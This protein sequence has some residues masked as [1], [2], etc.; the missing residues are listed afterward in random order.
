MKSIIALFNYVINN[1]DS[2][3][4]NILL[5]NMLKDNILSKELY[6]NLIKGLVLIFHL[7]N[8]LFS[9]Y[10][11]I[12]NYIILY[13]NNNNNNN[14]N[15]IKNIFNKLNN[16]DLSYQLKLDDNIIEK[17]IIYT[18]QY[19]IKDFTL[20]KLENKLITL[21]NMI[22]IIKQLNI[23]TELKINIYLQNIRNT[24]DIFSIMTIIKKYIN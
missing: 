11:N 1:D 10:Y 6:L 24:N 15:N 23:S 19:L 20:D 7:D 3:K 2:I 13:N 17:I 8:T 4:L 22:T 9:F 18:N 16:I 21:V 5:D 12:L 14:N